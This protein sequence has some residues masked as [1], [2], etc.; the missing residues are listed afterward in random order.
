MTG[1]GFHPAARA[2]LLAAARYYEQQA[3]G[4]GMQFVA[5]AERAVSLLRTSPR[6]G[7]PVSGHA[8]LRRWSLRRFPYYLIYRADAHALLILAVAHERRGPGYWDKR[9]G[10]ETT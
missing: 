10:S 5:E 9:L 8:E 4:L 7:A 6:L 1:V 3:Q 2:E